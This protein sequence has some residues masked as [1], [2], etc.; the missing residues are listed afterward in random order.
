MERQEEAFRKGTEE[1]FIASVPLGPWTSYS[2]L[3]DP[4]HMCFV[5]ARYKFCSK[6]LEG[7]AKILEVGCGDGFGG[8]FGL[9]LTSRNSP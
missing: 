6:M 3:N 8:F 2:L 4:K 9:F 7:K 1:Q 5:L